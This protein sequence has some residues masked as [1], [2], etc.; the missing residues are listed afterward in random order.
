MV[1]RR[2]ARPAMCCL[3]ALM[4]LG[5]GIAWAGDLSPSEAKSRIMN[6]GSGK[7]AQATVIM[8]NGT[9]LRG[10]VSQPGGEDFIMVTKERAQV[11]AYS[12]VA[13][14]KKGGFSTGAKA[15]I[16]GGIACGIGLILKLVL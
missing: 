12:D 7:K 2:L 10:Y 6:L 1:L 15:G 14:V 16:L 4:I 11:F 5:G 3:L 13:E 8:R 9:I